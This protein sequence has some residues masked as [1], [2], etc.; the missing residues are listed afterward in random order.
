M[1]NAMRGE[2][3]SLMATN[4]DIMEVASREGYGPHSLFAQVL[5]MRIGTSPN[6]L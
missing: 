2:R 3:A 6:A 1:L 5:T 4:V